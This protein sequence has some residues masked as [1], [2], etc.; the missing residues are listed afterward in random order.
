[1]RSFRGT[2][3]HMEL[4]LWGSSLPTP[5]GSGVDVQSPQTHEVFLRSVTVYLNNKHTK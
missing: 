3:T 5:I 1:M 2:L 4:A